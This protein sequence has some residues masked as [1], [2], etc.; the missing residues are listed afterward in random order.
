MKTREILSIVALGLLGVCLLCGLAKMAMKGLKAK[1]S[2]DQICSLLVFVAVVLIGV[3]QLLEENK[4]GY[5]D[6][7]T[8]NAGKITC[9]PLQYDANPSLYKQVTGGSIADTWG[10][11]SPQELQIETTDGPTTQSCYLRGMDDS[12]CT[13]LKNIY[14]KSP[15]KCH[16]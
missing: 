4:D 10:N 1:Q 13:N 6:G 3:S 15:R 7:E 5:M 11:L 14:K 16:S 2:C 8:Y 12:D 9:N